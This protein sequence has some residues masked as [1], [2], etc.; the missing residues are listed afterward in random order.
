[1]KKFLFIMVAFIAMTF[2]AQAQK[3]VSN[4]SIGN[5]QITF[6]V[7]SS[8]VENNKFSYY[9]ETLSFERG[10]E[11]GEVGFVVESKN[12]DCFISAVKEMKTKFIEYQKTS[13]QNNVTDYSK[14]LNINF[15]KMEGFFWYGE[16]H[17]DFN[18]T[19]SC[20]FM[21]GKDGRCTMGI[22][23]G[24]LQAS[25]NRFIKH[26]GAYIFFTSVEDFDS[27]IN[28]I[29]PKHAYNSAQVKQTTDALFN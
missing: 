24:N 20:K 9:I 26:D 27:F 23:L 28:A 12:I 18:R 11:I 21:V 25:D 7:K 19:P 14:E 10:D 29:D 2:Q 8:G 1:M 16:W 6:K 5:G 22:I 3:E 15:P 4:Y 17:F 13:I